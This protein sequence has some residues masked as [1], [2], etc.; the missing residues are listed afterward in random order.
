MSLSIFTRSRKG[1]YQRLRGKLQRNL[2]CGLAKIPS[3]RKLRLILT[4]KST[5]ADALAQFSV[6]RAG[7]A[8]SLEAQNTARD[9]SRHTSAAGHLQFSRKLI[10]DAAQAARS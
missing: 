9:D 3:G 6:G 4:V 7:F 10:V 2:P 8:G 5:N 1:P